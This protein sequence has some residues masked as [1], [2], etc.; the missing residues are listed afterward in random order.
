M[1]GNNKNMPKR[2]EIK[3]TANRRSN[4]DPQP[5]RLPLGQKREM[6]ANKQLQIFYF[7]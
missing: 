5:L 4:K 1:L 2:K 6:V 7:A 3:T